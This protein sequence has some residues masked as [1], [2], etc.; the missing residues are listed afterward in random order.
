MTGA[1]IKTWYA[2]KEGIDPEKIVSVS[3][4]PVRCEEVEIMRN[5]EAA[6]GLP[7]VDISITT[8]EL[9]RMIKMA[10]LNFQRLRKRSSTRRW[11]FHRRRDDLRRD[12]RRARGCAAHRGGRARGHRPRERRVHGDPRHAGLQ[13]G[14]VQGCGHGCE[15]CGR[16]RPQQ[17]ETSCSRRSRRARRITTIVEVMCCPGG[18]VNGGGQPIQPASVRKLYGHQGAARKGALR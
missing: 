11:R 18:C 13:G 12:G 3:V 4:M 14:R 2:E 5:D 1:L 17:R 10:Q 16:Q 8:R 7:D 15:G 9:A 6:A